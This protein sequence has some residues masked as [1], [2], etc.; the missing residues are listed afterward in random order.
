MNDNK[1][2]S[3]VTCLGQNDRD[4]NEMSSPTQLG[5][6]GRSVNFEV[7]ES[8]RARVG[9]REVSFQSFQ[10]DNFLGTKPKLTLF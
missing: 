1:G 6:V 2:S 4:G 5:K 3:K 7:Y 9:I 10:V 8:D